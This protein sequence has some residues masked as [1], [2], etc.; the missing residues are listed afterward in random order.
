MQKGKKKTEKMKKIKKKNKG[1]ACKQVISHED[2]AESADSEDEKSEDSEFLENISS[3]FFKAVK[4]DFQN[5]GHMLNTSNHFRIKMKK[6]ELC[7]DDMNAAF[8]RF[9]FTGGDLII[10]ISTLLAVGP[11]FSDGL[12]DIVRKRFRLSQAI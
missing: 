6:G 4:Y 1:E 3:E 9:L 10:I 2:K 5:D 8:K 11:H 7:M 12:A